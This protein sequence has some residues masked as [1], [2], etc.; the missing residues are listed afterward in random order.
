[1][2]RSISARSIRKASQ[3][4]VD[5]ALALGGL[6]DLQVRVGGPSS[7]PEAEVRVHLR[8]RALQEL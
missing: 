4:F 5:P 8:E 7:K 6:L 3:A 2:R 1:M